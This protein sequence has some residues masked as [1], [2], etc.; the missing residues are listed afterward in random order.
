MS[1]T[2][3]RFLAAAAGTAGG[4]LCPGS[5][6]PLL[7]RPFSAASRTVREAYF[8]EAMGNGT[9]R[10][11][12][13]PHGCEVPVDERGH[14]GCKVNLS[15][16]LYSISYQNP[17]SVNADPVEKKPLLHFQPGSRTFSLAVAGCNFTC[18]NC[19]NWEISQTT[20]DRT[21]NYDLPPEKAVEKALRY[22]CASIAYTYSEPT[23]FYEYMLDTAT[24]G[25]KQGLRNILVSN[26]YMNPEPL[27]RLCR[28]L[29]GASLNLKSFSDRTYRELNGG[30]LA[31]VLRS[32]E[33]VRKEGVW[34]E[35]INLIVPTWT[36][37]L[38]GIRRLC[39][40]IAER[41]GPDVP[42]HF[43][44]FFPQYR[45]VHLNPT[46]VAIMEQARKVALEEGLRHVYLGNVP[47]G[48]DTVACGGCGDPVVLRNGYQVRENRLVRGRCP[49]CDTPVAGVW[50]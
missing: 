46:P 31:P 48:G 43:S 19:Q 6:R 41:L 9:V 38:D 36:D 45:L 40:W 7:A 4:L 22:D 18:L 26:A 2:R 5:L 33:T 17:C 42:L 47:G 50:S 13:C 39:G 24:L 28:V 12:T 14:C 27:K 16:R 3:R 8:Q 1:T 44:R 25:R 29:D 37:D 30:S 15:G 35:I 49:G 32:L 20:P 34:L 21:R 23:T 10:C 11:G